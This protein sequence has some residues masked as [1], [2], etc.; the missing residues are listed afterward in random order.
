MKMKKILPLSL[1]GAMAVALTACNLN[2]VPTKTTTPA[3][4]TVEGNIKGNIGTPT[5]GAPGSVQTNPNL[6]KPTFA[7]ANATVEG[8]LLD[9]DGKP[10]AGA[11]VFA[12]NGQVVLT[13]ADGSYSI[14]VTTEPGKAVNLIFQKEGY[15]F[16][17]ETVTLNPGDKVMTEASVKKLDQQVVSVNAATG[18]TFKNYTGVLEVDVPANALTGNAQMSMTPLSFGQ[19]GAPNELP[20]SLETVD[21]SGARMLLMPAEYWS[22][23]LQGANLKEG[24]TITMR[25]RLPN[26][27]DAP[28]QLKEG[29]MIPC[30]I[31]DA[32]LGYWNSPN[33]GPVVK[34]DGVLWATYEI[35]ASA[36]TNRTDVI[37]NVQHIHTG[38]RTNGLSED[39][40]VHNA[41]HLRDGADNSFGGLQSAGGGVIG[42]HTYFPLFGTNMR[43]SVKD[44][45]GS[46]LTDASVNIQG[47][48]NPGQAGHLG[49][50]TFGRLQYRAQ[51]VTVKA[52]VSDFCQG[53]RGET[54][55]A[56]NKVPAPL[57]QFGYSTG[58]L[59]ESRNPENANW[60][61][62]KFDTRHNATLSFTGTAATNAAST[63]TYTLNDQP[64]TYQALTG[65]RH[66]LRNKS[67]TLK[68]KGTVD[69]GSSSVTFT[70][71]GNH[72]KG[73]PFP[74][75]LK[76]ALDADS[77]K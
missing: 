43:V 26:N 3:E 59:M 53:T 49:G 37:R 52:Y 18:G 35:K 73:A 44:W 50:G 30:Y 23:D 63:M 51:S 12:A 68:A 1:A 42:G 55:Q 36:L 76:F 14:G 27:P 4:G 24:E 74:V 22:I 60:A 19:A 40:L 9:S 57:N 13:E 77:V 62:F 10:V 67:Y 7:K 16:S 25:M 31:Y 75:S 66:L 41:E 34:K 33:L 5:T 6:A 8:K 65:T 47:G 45:D 64:I 21:E 61:E 17:S 72:T 56:S 71:P 38:S 15:V 29:D 11:Y 39:Q 48:G 2:G 69:Q 58:D 28:V 54:T 20:G 46:A 32:K 70:V